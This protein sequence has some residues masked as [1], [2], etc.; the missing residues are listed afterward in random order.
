ME[1]TGN[2]SLTVMAED[3]Y[4]SLIEAGTLLSVSVIGILCNLHAFTVMLR[5]QA[6]RNSFGRLAVC[7]TFSNVAVLAI[8]MV[9]ATPWTIWPVPDDLRYINLR[10]GALSICFF[11]MALHCHLFISINRFTAI[12]FP[13]YYRNKFTLYA[14]NAIIVFIGAGSFIFSCVFFIDGC[15]FFYGNFP[16]G[17]TY[18]TEL[19]TQYIALFVDYY[20]KSFLFLASIVLD[21]ITIA[22]LRSRRRKMV[23]R[24]RTMNAAQV[25][26]DTKM[27]R[28]EMRF[29]AQA[30]LGTFVNIFLYVAVTF[31]AAMVDARFRILCYTLSWE[32]VHAFAGV[33]FVV[34][35]P[36]IWRRL[37]FMEKSLPTTNVVTITIR[38]TTTNN[39]SKT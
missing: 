9:W 23:A 39:G 36:E 29:L 28:R 7:Y 10:V 1:T 19:C 5:H 20:Y 16:S 14:A 31:V 24:Q 3:L 33:I 4:I 15:D 30:A 21:T 8:F 25:R 34:F 18:G 26:D 38:A 17:W 37:P 6:F 2:N 13:V 22:Q 32:L 12:T 11:Q 27:E 35:N